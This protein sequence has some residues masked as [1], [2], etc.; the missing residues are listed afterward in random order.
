MCTCRCVCLKHAFKARWNISTYNVS[1]YTDDDN[2]NGSQWKRDIHYD[3][4]EEW[5]QLWYVGGQCVSDGLLQVVKDQTS[6]TKE[7]LAE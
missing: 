6:Y 7:R 3:V 1:S 4:E 2:G 5:N